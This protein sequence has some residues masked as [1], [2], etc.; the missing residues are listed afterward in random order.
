MRQAQVTAQRVMLD[1]TQARFGS[2]PSAW[3]IHEG[4]R[5]LVRDLSL[6]DAYLTSRRE[7]K[8][9]EMLFAPQAH[10][11]AGSPASSG[12]ERSARRVPPRRHGA[13]LRSSPHVCRSE[14]RLNQDNPPIAAGQASRTNDHDAPD[15]G[16][17]TLPWRRP[18]RTF[19][20]AAGLLSLSTENETSPG[21]NYAPISRSRRPS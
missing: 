7:R 12:R 15:T 10:P 13:R 9:V 2:G 14:T 19:V 16:R 5:D 6:T 17:S 1:R 11:E 20:Q 18:E 4:A 21:D 3:P 8:K